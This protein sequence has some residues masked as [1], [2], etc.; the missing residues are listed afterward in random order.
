MTN[1]YKQDGDK[2]P[3]MDAVFI[4][5]CR[6]LLAIASMMQDM[7]V[8]H[9]LLGAKNPFQEWRQLPDAKRRL[10]NAGARHALQPWAHNT[11]D[12]LP[13]TAGHL[14]I[15]HAIWGLMSAYE[16]H[17]EDMDKV[18]AMV[19]PPARSELEQAALELYYYGRWEL[20][21]RA[22]EP[23]DAVLWERLR[24][25]LGLP[26]GTTATPKPLPTLDNACKHLGGIVAGTCVDCHETLIPV[27]RADMLHERA[28]IELHLQGERQ[29][30]PL[31][32]P[33]GADWREPQGK[34]TDKCECGHS[35]CMHATA[36]P[37]HVCGGIKVLAKRTLREKRQT[38]L[39]RTFKA[40]AAESGQYW[41]G[42]SSTWLCTCGAGRPA[43]CIC[44][45]ANGEHS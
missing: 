30:S 4:P 29:A 20:P 43:A 42:D 11:K 45:R 16:M 41:T 38:C 23:Q 2:P 39:C 18:V 25:A 17:A 28:R 33:A 6:T 13:G 32:G 7:K 44:N 35:R 19:T 14:H 8:K 1:N 22:P 34:P 10:A 36:E 9:Q 37:V 40:Q 27:Q 3:V 12:A 31:H 5:Y 26:P 21:G 24:N 15:L